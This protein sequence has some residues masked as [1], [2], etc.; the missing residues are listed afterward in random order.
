MNIFLQPAGENSKDQLQATILRKENLENLKKYLT[1]EQYNELKNIFPNKELNMWGIIVNKKN[2]WEQMNKEDV[3]LF[4]RN[5]SFF[6]TSII[7]YKI[8]NSQLSFKIWGANKKGE[9]WEYIY[10]LD[11]VQNIN[12]PLED[13]KKVTGYRFSHVQGT[14]R[15]KDENVEKI[16]DKYDDY[17]K[18]DYIKNRY[19]ENQTKIRELEKRIDNIDIQNTKDNFKIINLKESQNNKKNK[20][21]TNKNYHKNNEERNKT[22][23][24]LSDK[25]KYHLGVQGELYVSKLLKERN[26]YLLKEINL[27]NQ[28]IEVICYNEGYNKDENWQDKSID[29]GHDI[30]LKSKKDNEEIYLEIKTSI[31]DT[32]FFSMTGNELKFAR[33]KGNKYYIIKITSFTDINKEQQ[34]SKLRF[35]VIQNPYQLIEK[36]ENIKEV[37]MYLNN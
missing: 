20:K 7:K 3:V 22:T 14:M 30:L 12:I 10:F 27:L 1:L 19:Y 31:D 6:I 21:V 2:V 35:Y 8:H 34:N 33:E 24:Y 28:D 4:Y 17:L 23:E 36:G 37:S 5:K 9:S 16:L 13:F 26:K 15:V 29:K 32:R 11:N 25:Y 18:L